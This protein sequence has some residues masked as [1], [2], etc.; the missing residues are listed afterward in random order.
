MEEMGDNSIICEEWGTVV[1]ERVKNGICNVNNIRQSGG[2]VSRKTSNGDDMKVG[3]YVTKESE[4]R[5]TLSKDEMDKS[6]D[7]TG[8]GVG[9]AERRG[10]WNASGVIEEWMYRGVRG[11]R[12]L[13][14][15]IRVG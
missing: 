6:S 13:R 4:L 15:R 11:R 7:C 12:S 9:R 1:L 5:I 14:R 2:G 3:D 10:G 8:E